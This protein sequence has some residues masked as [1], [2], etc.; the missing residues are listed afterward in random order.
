MRRTPQSREPALAIGLV[1]ICVVLFAEPVAAQST[2][3]LLQKANLIYQGAFRVPEGTTTQTEFDY[4]GT[5]LAYN[6]VNSSLYM[7]GHD[8]YQLSAEISI[9]AIVNSTNLSDLA[10]AVLLQPLADATE[11]KLNSINPSDPNS[12]KIGDHLVYNG[13]LYVSA[14]SYYDGSGTQTVSHFVRPLNLSTTGQVLGPFQVGTQYPGFV[15]G[16]MTLVPPEWQTALGGP[17]LTGGCCHAI[18]S[19]QSNGP[20]ASVFDPA[21]VGSTN[22]APATPVVGYPYPQSLG[23]GWGTTNSLYNGST[24]I[25]GIVFPQ[26]T[27]SVLFFGRH[28]TG[29]FCY[30]SGTTDQSLAGT[31]NPANG[32]P[33]CYDLAD[34]SKGTHA[35]PYVYQVWAYDANDLLAV[36]NGSKAQYQI[37]PYAT[38]NFNLPFENANDPHLLGGTGYDPQTN[39]IYLAQRCEDTN[40]GP[41]IH[42]LRV[43]GSL[44]VPSP[45]TSVQVK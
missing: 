23:P 15:S 37:Q 44:S 20:A 30:G 18:T 22:P 4:G 32:D 28:G 33:W 25:T 3:P 26:G 45:P 38:W 31:T 16:Y 35:F 9:P 12:K 2:A 8:W 29:P 21:R 34:Q 11:G 41:I 27:R 43:N 10:T 1:L 19:I 40:C 36:K 42:V 39:N 14:Y 13:K 24:Q 5:A 7:T 6:P 17:A